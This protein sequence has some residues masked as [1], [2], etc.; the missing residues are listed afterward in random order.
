MKLFDSVCF[1]KQSCSFLVVY[2]DLVNKTVFFCWF[3]LVLYMKLLVSVGLCNF[4]NKSVCF[5]WFYWFSKPKLFVSVYL[6]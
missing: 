5:C 1:C 4:V 2:V 3:L 6:C